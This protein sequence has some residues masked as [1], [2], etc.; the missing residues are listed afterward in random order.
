[1]PFDHQAPRN[2]DAKLVDV[3]EQKDPVELVFSDETR[4]FLPAGVK[5]VP[6]N[7]APE[8]I[9]ADASAADFPEIQVRM[10]VVCPPMLD[11]LTGREK[12]H[13]NRWLPRFCSK[14]YALATIKRIEQ[15]V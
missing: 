10:L 1:M 7:H 4:L 14:Q 13:P 3:H 9:P 5:L 6:D 2:L 12:P 11:P 15:G 8:H